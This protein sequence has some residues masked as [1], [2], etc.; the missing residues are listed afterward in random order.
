MI[1]TPDI[2]ARV[3]KL[4]ADNPKMQPADIA[5][6]LGVQVRDFINAWRRY[7]AV[8][9]SEIHRADLWT[10]ERIALLHKRW[11]QG[12]I[13]R[14][15][16]AELG[17]DFNSV[18][19]EIRRRKLP[20]RPAIGQRKQGFAYMRILREFPELNDP[21]N[22]TIPMPTDEEI[23]AVR[24]A[25]IIRA[26]LHPERFECTPVVEII[27]RQ[28]LCR[29]SS[30]DLCAWR[31]SKRHIAGSAYCEKHQGWHVSATGCRSSLERM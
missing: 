26:S 6:D 17:M 29:A 23:T 9:R 13:I 2:I 12:V 14:T 27:D 10:E 3:L 28:D 21:V 7:R 11:A 30:N 20:R 25:E 16:A 5:I 4:Q 24:R 22:R 31:C 1:L 15:I 18:H 19:R 8:V